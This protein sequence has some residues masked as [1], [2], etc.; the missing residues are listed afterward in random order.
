M[1]SHTSLHLL[2]W[3]TSIVSSP[4]I[5]STAISIEDAA[6]RGL[7]KL[8]IKGKGGYT[9]KVIEFKIKN[10]TPNNLNLKLE[11]GRRLDSKDNTQQDILVTQAQEFYVYGNQQKNMSVNGMCC[12][13]SNA[14]PKTNSD[15]LVGKMADS[16][17]VKLA[18]F[19]DKNKY[20]ENYTAQQAVW[21]ISDNK[22]IASIYGGE[23]DIVMGLRKYVSEI[24]GKPIP[25]YNITYRQEHDSLA[26][27]RPLKIEGIFDYTLQTTGHVTLAIFNSEGEIVQY[28]CKELAHDKG[29]HK[30][31]YTFKTKDLPEGTYYAKLTN[32]GRLEKEMKIEY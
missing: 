26:I 21:C 5:A 3:A 17:L 6:K 15:Y 18:S 16:N 7:I 14:C 23:K 4:I 2:V 19:I 28:I 10:N 13:A 11:A 9:G 27:G 29:E 12:Q 25:S 32:E 20:Y 31:Y 22:S 30:I 1:K 8:I 24:T